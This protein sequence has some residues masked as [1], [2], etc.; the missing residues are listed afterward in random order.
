MPTTRRTFLQRTAVCVIWLV[1]VWVFVGCRMQEA[2]GNRQLANRSPMPTAP[3]ATRDKVLPTAITTASVL[4]TATRD[5]VPPTATTAASALPTATAIKASRTPARATATPPPLARMS[6]SERNALYFKLLAARQA[7]G[8]ETAT[9][10][11]EYAQAIELMFAG[12]FA[13]AD[14]KLNQAITALLP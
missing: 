6:F 8:R 9:A 14:K 3:A 1:S 4:P 7:E 13:A 11:A 2:G 12:D 10:E 5:K